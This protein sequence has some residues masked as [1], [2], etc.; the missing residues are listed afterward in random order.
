MKV[1]I[2]S[3]SLMKEEAE[4]LESLS[5]QMGFENKSRVI[6][7]ALHILNNLY[8]KGK[9]KPAEINLEVERD[10]SINN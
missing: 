7:L 2:Y 1:K 6:R 10:G 8:K 3:F 9:V 4:F 5:R